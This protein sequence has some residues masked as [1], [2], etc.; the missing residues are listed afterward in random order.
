MANNLAHFDHLNDLARFE[1]F[2]GIE[3]FFRN[4]QLRNMSTGL[5]VAPIIKMDVSETEQAYTV[6]AEI[7]G[8]KK[9]D[10][11]I[12]IEGNQVSIAA[13]TKRESEQKEGNTVVR[14]ERY[15]GQQYRSFTLAHDIDDANAVAQYQDGVLELTL[16][17]K[18]K[19]GTT[20]AVS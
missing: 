2:R 4:F 13:E 14:S 5:D 18:A 20:L 7:P 15:F 1:P 9:E 6:N 3:D 8:M 10:I 11:K 16:P 12:R 17:K 19:N